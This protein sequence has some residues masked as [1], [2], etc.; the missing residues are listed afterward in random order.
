MKWMLRA[1]LAALLWPAS[2]QAADVQAPANERFA[3]PEGDETPS[4]RRHL[5]PLMG[6]LGCNG[7]ACHGSFQGRGGFRLS[8]FGYDFQ[9]DHAALT[10][11]AEPRVDINDPA[12][13]L[14]LQKPTLGIDHEGGR[15]MESGSWQYHVFRRWIAGGAKGIAENEPEIITLQVEPRE[16]VF[17]GD[18]EQAQL[19]VVAVWAD[20]SKEDVTPLC[21]FRSNDEAIASIS[22]EGLVKIVG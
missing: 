11:G 14:L 6:R 1:G 12:S 18:G 3:A 2:L 8:L 22:D 16:L 19:R 7:R 17:H 9:A 4:F 13:S 10:K 21:R 15:R 5:L 20:G